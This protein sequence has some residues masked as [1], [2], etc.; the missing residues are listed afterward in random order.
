VL[1]VIRRSDGAC[2]LGSCQLGCLLLKA[3]RGS[4]AVEAEGA[5]RVDALPHTWR[6][7]DEQA[8]LFRLEDMT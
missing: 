6:A 3:G 8:E 2:P 5:D 1:V 4:S 7:L